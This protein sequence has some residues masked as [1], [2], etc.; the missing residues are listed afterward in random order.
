M[1]IQIIVKNKEHYTREKGVKRIG[2]L[3]SPL[4]KKY[5][6]RYEQLIQYLFLA[7]EVPTNLYEYMGISNNN[8]RK[9][10]FKLR[11][12][13]IIRTVRS[14]SLCGYTLTANGKERLSKNK[15][16]QVCMQVHLFTA[17]RSIMTR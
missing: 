11:S 2:K 10:F 15:N 13:N 3:Q 5:H 16:Y 4:P 17:F 7:G 12:S 14:G 8:Y 1:I 9:L 6:L